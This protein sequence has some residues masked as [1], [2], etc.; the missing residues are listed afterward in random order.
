MS[1]G[2]ELLVCH[3]AEKLRRKRELTLGYQVTLTVD[4]L[5]HAFLKQII[6]WQSL[7]A[8]W[9]LYY[10][11]EQIPTAY[12]DHLPMLLDPT[13][14]YNNVGKNFPWEKLAHFATVTLGRLSLPIMMI[15]TAQF[16]PNWLSD[17]R[18]IGKHVLLKDHQLTH[19]Q[20]VLPIDL[21]SR[22]S[23]TVPLDDDAMKLVSSIQIMILCALGVACQT[24][25]DCFKALENVVSL[26]N[27]KVYNKDLDFVPMQP[28]LTER[29]VCIRCPVFCSNGTA[30][31]YVFWFN[32][33]K[34]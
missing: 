20:T 15:F 10:S 22:I 21:F 25:G 27:A 19:E 7:R 23:Y 12:F 17:V 18:L 2:I 3:T 28:D 24:G 29:S 8:F 5:F 4:S 13:N 9:T 11:K 34:I 32:T 33:L 6:D 14:P 31:T 16:D 26:F 30:I 1:F